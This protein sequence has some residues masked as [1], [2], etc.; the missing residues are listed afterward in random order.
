MEQKTREELIKLMQGQINRAL[1]L[2]LETCSRCGVCT[3]A[4]H[5]HESIPLVKYIPAYTWWEI[6]IL[7]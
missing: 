4:C 5:V 2:Y 1:K 6:K 3:K 7:N